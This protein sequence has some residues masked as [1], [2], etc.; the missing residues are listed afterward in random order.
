MKKY[1]EEQLD[2]LRQAYASMTVSELTTAF[3]TRFGLQYTVSAIRSTINR[4]HIKRSRR[5]LPGRYR[6]FT[7]EQYDFIRTKY[8]SMSLI[9][10]TAAFNNRFSCGKTE[11]QLRTFVRNHGLKSGRSGR[12]EKGQDAWNKGVKGYMGANVTSFKKGNV[13]KNRKPLGSE[14]IDAKDGYIMVKIA[15]ADPYTGFP[16]RYKAKHVVVWERAHGGKVPAGKIVFFL[17]GDKTNCTPENLELISRAEAIRL[18]QYGYY[19]LPGELRPAMLSLV[20]L[21]ARANKLARSSKRNACQRDVAAD[22]SD[23]YAIGGMS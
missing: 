21:Q 17:D 14:R 11:R 3:N 2:F 12:F 1:T 4:R 5:I 15:E 8:P 22:H 7:C 18:V 20:R 19:D 16:T 6:S 9:D 23:T 13:P 10:L